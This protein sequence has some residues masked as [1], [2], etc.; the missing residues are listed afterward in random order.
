ML[1]MRSPR[2]LRSRLLGSGLRI[3]IGG[4]PVAGSVESFSHTIVPH[5]L[6]PHLAMRICASP[7]WVSQ[8]PVGSAACAADI[9][10]K[11]RQNAAQADRMACRVM[12]VPGDTE[13]GDSGRAIPTRC[14]RVVNPSE[15]GWGN[16]LLFQPKLCQPGVC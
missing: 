14:S 16:K 10:P 2:I 15:G 5:M 12:S 8:R 13:V 11:A 4:W 1:K 9:A 7:F 3:S 6:A